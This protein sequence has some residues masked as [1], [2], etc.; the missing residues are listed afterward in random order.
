MRLPWGERNNTA[1]GDKVDLGLRRRR[2]PSGSVCEL[3][4]VILP[5]EFAQFFI[6]KGDKTV[7]CTGLS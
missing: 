2:L 3:E 6:C 4:K 5:L 7:N 1:G